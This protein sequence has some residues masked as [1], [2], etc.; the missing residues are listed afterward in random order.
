ML[1]SIFV[2]TIIGSMSIQEETNIAN[3]QPQMF[4]PYLR[5]AKNT[6]LGTENPKVFSQIVFYI[7]IVVTF[8]FGIWSSVS[9]FI[10]KT[11]KYLKQHKQVD[12]KAIVELRGRE[13]GFEGETF[14]RYLELFHFSSVCLWICI[15]AGLIF[16]WRKKKWSVYVIITGLI[17]YN[18]LMVFMLG[19]TYFIEDTTLFDKLTL[20]V[21]FLL[22][23]IHHFVMGT[24]TTEVS[25]ETEE[26]TGEEEAEEV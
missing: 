14:Y 19:P 24:T 13:L 15:L 6:V 25:E 2:S 21:F 8:I 16:F 10:L 5:R 4:R 1:S 23:L 26:T 12:V 20:L 3:N 7:G 22:V 18:A 17:V 9:Y 11:P